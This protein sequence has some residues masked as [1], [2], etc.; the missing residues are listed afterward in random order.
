MLSMVIIVF[1]LQMLVIYLPPLQSF[2]DTMPLGIVDLLIATG[3][4]MAMFGVI[5]AGKFFGRSR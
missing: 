2:F 1:S 3:I 4:G 5:E